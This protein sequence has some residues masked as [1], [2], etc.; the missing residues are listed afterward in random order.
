METQR[1]I[2]IHRV[3]WLI[4]GG[5]IVLTVTKKDKSFSSS[6]LLI[7]VQ[8]WQQLSGFSVCKSSQLHEESLQVSET[9]VVGK[10]LRCWD[11][12]GCSSPAEAW[13]RPGALSS[14]S[15]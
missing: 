1:F 8:V 13:G 6:S 5:E 14:Y 3:L 4:Q 10:A 9:R 15:S 7:L 12:R 11:P 2:P